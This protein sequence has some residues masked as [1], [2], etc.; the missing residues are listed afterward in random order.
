MHA[1]CARVPCFLMASSGA[2]GR[3]PLHWAVLGDQAAAVAF[4]LD[5][6]AW[7]EASDAHDDTPLHLAARQGSKQL[8]LTSL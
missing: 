6:G 5:K 2:G 7:V 1:I 3:T 8:P 4:L